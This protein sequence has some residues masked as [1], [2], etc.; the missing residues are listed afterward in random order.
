MGS[1]NRH[2]WW[3]SLGPTTSSRLLKQRSKQK[4]A[5][6]SPGDGDFTVVNVNPTPPRGDNFANSDFIARNPR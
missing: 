5:H 6:L 1:A 4:L 3:A 2:R